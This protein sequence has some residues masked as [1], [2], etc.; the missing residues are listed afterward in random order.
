[1]CLAVIYS[2]D[3]KCFSEGKTKDDIILQVNLPQA[4]PSEQQ[5]WV[6][7]RPVLWFWVLT[8]HPTS[9][10]T[11]KVLNHTYVIHLNTDLCHQNQHSKPNFRFSIFKELHL[12]E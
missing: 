4:L 5:Y 9:G 11:S 12:D 2:G 3:N 10:T 7:Y 1:M 8:G 6:K